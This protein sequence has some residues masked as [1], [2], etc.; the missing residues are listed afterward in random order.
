MLASRAGTEAPPPSPSAVLQ[1]ATLGDVGEARRF[2]VALGGA[3]GLSE[4]LRSDVGIVVTELATNLV[5]HGGG[6]QLILRPLGQGG[7]IEMLG[8]DQGPG[9]A[10]IAECLRDGYSSAG[11]LG[12]G[13]GAIQRIGTEFDLFSAPGQGTVVMVRIA[14]RRS[15]GARPGAVTA[16]V[17]VAKPGEVESGDGWTAVTSGSRT[18]I[19]VVDGLGHGPVAA[20][21]ATAGRE[22]FVRAAGGTPADVLEALH[23]ALRSTRGAAVAVAIADREAQLVRFGGVGNVGGS[24]V[25]PG[26]QRSMVS[27]NGIVGHQMH[28]VREFEYPWPAGATMVL[29]TDGLISHWKT[30]AYQGVLQRDPALLCALLYRDFSRGRDDTTVVACRAPMTN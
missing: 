27:H 12:S 14:P 11:S 22:A 6:G 8:V 17:C 26:A 24:I 16:G 19:C 21:A 25:T 4:S 30:D 20:E 29:Y 15:E 18:A 28:R 10:S 1:V 13:L 23:R 9:M 7:G 2:A 5:R 3:T